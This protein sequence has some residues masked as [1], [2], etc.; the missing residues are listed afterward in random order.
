LFLTAYPQAV[1]IARRG[2]GGAEKFFKKAL[3]N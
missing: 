2:I 3:T 1:I